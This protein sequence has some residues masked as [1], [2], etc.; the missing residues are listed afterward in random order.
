MAYRKVRSRSTGS[1]QEPFILCLWSKFLERFVTV[2]E[3][4]VPVEARRATG[5]LPL[6]CLLQKAMGLVR[7]SGRAV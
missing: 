2:D 7:G 5:D 4:V 1:E 6:Y 3:L